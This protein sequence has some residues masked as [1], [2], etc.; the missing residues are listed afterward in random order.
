MEPTG[1]QNRI[2]GQTRSQTR[3]Y[4]DT[5]SDIQNS[6]S[7]SANN[8]E[9]WELG[10][11]DGHICDSTLEI[12]RKFA[13]TVT[14]A[15]CKENPN[16]RD[17]IERMAEL[18]NT[19][20]HIPQDSKH[21]MAETILNEAQ[22]QRDKDFGHTV[23]NECKRIRPDLEKHI[24][25]VAKMNDENA[26]ITRPYRQGTHDAIETINQHGK[27]LNAEIDKFHTDTG[28]L[29][30]SYDKKYTV[31]P[32]WSDSL[33]YSK[34]KSLT[35]KPADTCL[36]SHPHLRESI[37]HI[38]ECVRDDKD[39][40]KG[41][42]YQEALEYIYNHDNDIR[43]NFSRIVE[44]E[45][46]ETHPQYKE[47]IKELVDSD[48]D[49]PLPRPYNKKT[50]EAYTIIL[51]HGYRTRNK[52][53]SL[54]NGTHSKDCDSSIKGQH[55]LMNDR[56]NEHPLLNLFQR[57]ESVENPET[58]EGLEVICPTSGV[59][60]K[61]DRHEATLVKKQGE[62][63]SW[64]ARHVLLTIHS[65]A[66]ITDAAAT[67]ASLK[68]EGEERMTSIGIWEGVTP[69]KPEDQL[70]A[71]TPEQTRKR[72]GAGTWGMATPK[73]WEI[74]QAELFAI[75]M[76]LKRL[77]DRHGSYTTHRRVLIASDCLTGINMIEKA[78]RKKR[79]GGRGNMCA[80]VEVICKYIKE[81]EMVKL[82]YIPGHSGA[83]PNS[84]ADAIAKS[85]LGVQAHPE[86]ITEWINGQVTSRPC[87]L[88]PIEKGVKGTTPDAAPYKYAKSAAMSWTRTKL[89]KNTSHGIRA[90]STTPTWT[91]VKNL[92]SDKLTVYERPQKKSKKD[93]SKLVDSEI[94]TNAI[95]SKDLDK[96]LEAEMSRADK[97]DTQIHES[98]DDESEDGLDE[99]ADAISRTGIMYGI[100]VNRVPGIEGCSLKNHADSEN[101]PH[102][103]CTRELASGC[104]AKGCSGTPDALHVI[105]GKCKALDD[106][107]N[108]TYIDKMRSHIRILLTSIPQNDDK[109]RCPCKSVIRMAD[110]AVRAWRYKNIAKEH[111]WI[112]FRQLLSGIIPESAA[113]REKGPADAKAKAIT[114]QV[115]RTISELQTTVAE[116]VKQRSDATWKD[117]SRRKHLYR[118][119]WANE[120]TWYKQHTDNNALCATI[121]LENRANI[122]HLGEL[123]PD[124]TDN[125]ERDTCRICLLPCINIASLT[126]SKDQWAHTSCCR[127]PI[128]ATC[129]NKMTNEKT[130]VETSH[131]QIRRVHT[132]DNLMCPMCQ[133][134]ET[135]TLTTLYSEDPPMTENDANLTTTDDN[136]DI[137]IDWYTEQ[138]GETEA[139]N[140]ENT[141]HTRDRDPNRP[142]P[143]TEPDNGSDE[144]DTTPD[145]NTT[146]IQTDTQPPPNTHT[147]PYTNTTDK[148]STQIPTIYQILNEQCH[149]GNIHTHTHTQPYNIPDTRLL[150][151]RRPTRSPI[152]HDCRKP[153]DTL[154]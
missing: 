55:N 26:E 24:S 68:G 74:T 20:A 131:Q 43:N 65:H 19:E 150:R 54:T 110:L 32:F 25:F 81:F 93:K 60:I 80:I 64:G 91:K 61:F 142:D 40:P 97:D 12:N 106:D 35:L 122:A 113:V 133:T 138:E 84:Y 111:E 89:K 48:T 86:K 37:D 102:G 72:V 73:D 105:S 30:P 127:E 56:V 27:N 104:I 136:N 70:K 98:E 22:T 87:I 95:S 123:P 115:A 112:A 1:L 107:T 67:D 4:R 135:P 117:Q 66:K 108:T 52:M 92:I 10:T 82:V 126:Q 85:H 141:T 39:I 137:P 50:C 109:G 83:T 79:A 44:E 34:Y 116:Y 90:E 57:C 134:P 120:Q 42:K 125:I 17:Q 36:G 51:E 154:K 149:T 31:G 124:H 29:I 13:T 114:K 58:K 9:P 140:I 130:Q 143:D 7:I 15:C 45:C 145:E 96:T 16:L 69:R 151:R 59:P 148:T 100:A 152:T 11:A 88:C 49:T 144:S 129:L 71:E 14:E 119:D 3:K 5:N 75:L 21:K 41:T 121:E 132:I 139:Y 99:R 8:H 33:D 47:Q 18:Q 62:E 147:T 118:R 103:P 76:Y 46:I 53:L 128:H 153:R 38:Q 101:N 2:Y 6:T 146:N 94:I 28:S 23:I 63:M 77:K 78:L